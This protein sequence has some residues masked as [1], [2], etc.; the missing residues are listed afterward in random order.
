MESFKSMLENS[1]GRVLLSRNVQDWRWQWGAVTRANDV[2]YTDSRI[3]REKCKQWYFHVNYS[4][5]Y[6][7][8]QTRI[9]AYTRVYPLPPFL[10]L[11]ELRVVDPFLF[12]PNTGI[13]LRSRLHE[14]SLQ[15]HEPLSCDSNILRKQ[16]NAFQ[17][18]RSQKARLFSYNVQQYSIVW[19]H[20]FIS[21]LQV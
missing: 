10:S 15:G 11:T 18:Q 17:R 2:L 9:R 14:N 16:W 4:I 3:F 1:Q 8:S 5:P 20:D 7:Q 12:A 6:S 13:W 19:V 21:A